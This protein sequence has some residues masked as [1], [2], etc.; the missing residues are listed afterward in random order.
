MRTATTP[1]T[2]A[3]R[4][5]RSLTPSQGRWK[6]FVRRGRERDRIPEPYE[7][8][9]QALAGIGVVA[10]GGA[11]TNAGAVLFCRGG[12]PWRLTMGLCAGNDRAEILD[13]RQEDGPV[14][15]LVDRG[16]YFVMSNIR[17]RFS[18]DG[19]DA[20]RVET[21]EIPK[22]AVREGTVNAFCYR[23]WEDPSAV[24]I[25]VFRDTVQINNPGLFPEGKPPEAFIE[26]VAR[27][28]RPR[29]P[30]IAAALYKGGLIET[31]GSGI[32]RIRDACAEA[33]VRFEYAQEYGCTTLVFHRPAPQ[34]GQAGVSPRPITR[35]D[36]V[37][38]YLGQHGPSTVGEISD[39]L[40]LGKRQIQRVLKSLV[41]DGSVMR[42]GSS[43]GTAYALAPGQ[44]AS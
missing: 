38:A 28:S 18:F 40:P 4:A 31:Y 27:P 9:A 22:A 5:R 24:V 41:E 2:G 21:P 7:T 36:A 14:A 29:N 20:V 12:S 30:G 13:L 44:S 3:P 6:R 11:L 8:D 25:D 33:G 16:E 39:A 42:L 37:L 10:E 23:D 17:R 19:P 1:G 15:G 34:A 32:K 35:S 43:V 26:G